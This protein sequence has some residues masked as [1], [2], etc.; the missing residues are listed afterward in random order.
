MRFLQSHHVQMRARRGFTLVEAVMAVGLVG[1]MLV[2]ALNATGAI[3][4]GEMKIAD[5]RRGSL[6]AQSLM[7]EIMQ[8]NYEEPDLADGEGSFDFKGSSQMTSSPPVGLDAG[9][10]GGVRADFDDVD[11]YHGWSASPPEE[12]DGTTAPNLVGWR[13]AVAID[14]VKGGDLDF[15]VGAAT[16]FK[17]ITVSVE[18]LDNPIAQ[19]VAIRTVGL[20]ASSGGL[21]VLFVAADPAALTAQETLRKTMIE[22]WAFDVTLIADSATQSDFD[23]AVANADVAYVSTDI[24][25]NDLGTKLRE[26]I[27]GI[28]NEDMDVYDDFGF[29]SSFFWYNATN[30]DIV[31]NT[32]YIT[33]PFSTGVLAL[34]SSTQTLATVSGA[35]APDLQVLGTKTSGAAEALVVLETGAQMYDGGTAAGRRAQLPWGSGGVDINSLTDDAKTIMQRAIEWAANQEQP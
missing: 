24:H 21:R 29:S 17:R 30:I 11:D 5:N 35:L 8:Q 2:V 10:S 18:Y 32:H 15:V 4:L 28:V 9:E 7:S 20:P 16:G 26:T 19:L 31:D 13:R 23:E 1:G 34:Y 6:L 33:S 25:G 3:R 27:I 12:K 22:S 14:W